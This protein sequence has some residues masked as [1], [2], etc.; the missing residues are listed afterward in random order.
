MP[1]SFMFTIQIEHLVSVQ[2]NRERGSL[3]ILLI[4]VAKPQEQFY[5]SNI[6]FQH[7]DPIA[8]LKVMFERV[9]LTVRRCRQF[10]S[11][12]FVSVRYYALM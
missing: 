12:I 8:L 7:F 3:A 11:N 6:L 4:A 10:L 2:G 9:D 1:L 5:F